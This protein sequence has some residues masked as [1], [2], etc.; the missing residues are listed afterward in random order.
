L[1]YWRIKFLHACILTD[2][3]KAFRE[4]L[5][6]LISHLFAGESQWQEEADLVVKTGTTT[7]WYWSSFFSLQF[8]GFQM[9]G[10]INQS[11]PHSPRCSRE[12]GRRT[13]NLRRMIW[14][15]GPSRSIPWWVPGICACSKCWLPKYTPEV[16][17]LVTAWARDLEEAYMTLPMIPLLFSLLSSFL[18]DVNISSCTGIFLFYNV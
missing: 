18:S 12:K 16:S 2:W 13:M 6:D 11:S 3:S 15:W 7:W 10:S 8:F 1:K 14:R 5:V 17:T 9:H 4:H